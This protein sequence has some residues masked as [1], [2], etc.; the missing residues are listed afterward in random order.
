[1][2]YKPEPIVYTARVAL[3]RTNYS[4]DDRVLL[5]SMIKP[6]YKIKMKN[7]IMK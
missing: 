2:G 7:M 6:K 4:T 1:M 5:N 3:P